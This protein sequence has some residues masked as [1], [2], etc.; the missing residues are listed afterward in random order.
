MRVNARRFLVGFTLV[1]LDKFTVVFFWAILPIFAANTPE[2]MEEV[3]WTLEL[4]VT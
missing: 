4:M 1:F 3:L 2:M